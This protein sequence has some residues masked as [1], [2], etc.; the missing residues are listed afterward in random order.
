MANLDIARRRMM[1]QRIN[2]STLHLPQD[3]VRWMGA[4]QSQ[5]YAGAKWAV[6]LRARVAEAVVEQ[7]V[8]TGAIVRVHILRPTWHLVA[9]EDV[10]W[11]Q[12]LT[13]PR[14]KAGL[15][16]RLRALEID[17][18]VLARSQEIFRKVLAGGRQMTRAALE[19]AL[20]Q[21]GIATSV[22]QRLVHLLLQAELDQV[23]VNG[24]W[25]GKQATYALLDERIPERD[26]N[27][28]LLDAA[29]AA[30]ELALRFFTSHGPAT[31]KDFI[32]WSSLTAAAARAGIVQAGKRLRR[33]EIDGQDYWG[34][35][36]DVQAPAASSAEVL[37]PVA[38][39]LPNYD[40][41]VVAYSDRTAIIDRALPNR[42]HLHGGILNNVVVIDG[43]VAG[44][45]KR[46]LTRQ[47]V[48]VQIEPLGQYSP[49]AQQAVEEAVQHYG[50]Y[51]GLDTRLETLPIS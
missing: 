12:R 2:S 39:L 10:R 25:E 42:L 51:L 43:F 19:A 30:A 16:A 9:A 28:V 31:L 48:R 6:G 36:P 37:R 18:A 15:A 24:A 17:T 22:P 49:E 38:H 32:W 46:T 20:N 14:V 5:D 44:G 23:L 45:W 8:T 13:A 3:I 21:G 29:P 11:M 50:R 40:E 27:A 35:N 1:N 33:E 26:T 7:A 4:V 34:Q 41:Y 47:A